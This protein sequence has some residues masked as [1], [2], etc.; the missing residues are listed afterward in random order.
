MRPPLSS[1]YKDDWRVK[2]LASLAANPA[3]GEALDAFMT[4]RIKGEVSNKIA[5]FLSSAT[6]VV[7]LLKDAETMA[8][9]KRLHGDK[10]R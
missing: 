7:L 1:P 9:M 5:D 4:T 2:H 8:E 6:L 10:Y 3:C